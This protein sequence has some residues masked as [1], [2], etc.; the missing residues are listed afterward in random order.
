MR[1][2]KPLLLL[3]LPL[4]ASLLPAVATAQ[5][6]IKIAYIEGLSGPFANVGEIGLR[7]YQIAAEAVNARGGVLGGMKFEIVPFDHKTSPQEAQLVFKQATDQGIRYIAQGNGSSV[8]LALA[9]A[10]AKNNAR[11]PQKTVIFLNYAAVDPAL[12][13][14]KCNPWHFRFDADADMKMHAL[15]NYM[16]QQKSIRKVYLINQDYSFGHAVAKAA[17]AMLGAK[18][19]DTEIVGDDLHPLGKV[20]DFSPYVGKIKASGADSVIT[21]N[22]GNDLALLIKAGKD[23]GLQVDYYTFYAGAAGA[24]TAFGD[25]GV[26]R[27]KQVTTWHANIGGKGAAEHTVAYRARFPDFKDDLYYSSIRVSVEMLARAMEQA[28]SADPVKVALAMEGLKYE[29]DAGEVTMRADNH[30]LIQPLFISTLVRTNGKDV[31][32]DVEKTGFGYRTDARI[33]GKDTFMPTTCQM[34]KP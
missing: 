3:C 6:T 5:G 18:R 23:A 12:T 27:V 4:L 7:H 28:R 25:A 30:Q 24:I 34:Q 29:D 14:E 17:R 1:L 13:N 10:V 21:G 15:T 32:F 16:A 2:I 20:K 9:D 19:P 11:N 31:K 33:E 8:A 22:W 26:G